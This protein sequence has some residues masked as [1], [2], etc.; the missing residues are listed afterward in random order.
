MEIY[1]SFESLGIVYSDLGSFFF[2]LFLKKCFVSFF[3]INF[4]FKGY[5][6]FVNFLFM[7]IV[8]KCLY[9]YVS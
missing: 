8:N 2:I 7:N 1:V 3:F 4:F 6:F 5:L 9:V